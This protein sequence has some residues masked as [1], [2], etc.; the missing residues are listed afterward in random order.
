MAD[1]KTMVAEEKDDIEGGELDMD[2]EPTAEE[3]AEAKRIA[4]KWEAEQNG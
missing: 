4:D 2:V 3:I 1:E